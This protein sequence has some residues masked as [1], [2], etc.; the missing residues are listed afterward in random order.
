MNKIK[1]FKIDLI[2]GDISVN[3]VLKKLYEKFLE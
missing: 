3:K 2:K 1:F